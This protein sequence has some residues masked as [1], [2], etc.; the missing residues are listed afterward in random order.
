VAIAQAR[1]GLCRVPE[2][3]DA[4]IVSDDRVSGAQ[5]LTDRAV[6]L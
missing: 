3:I 4:D 5:V 6:V 2:R 1:P